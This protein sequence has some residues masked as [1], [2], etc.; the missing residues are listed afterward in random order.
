MKFLL[1]IP[2]ILTPLWA[3]AQTANCTQS[4]NGT[5]N[6]VTTDAYG[7]Q[8]TSTVTQTPNGFQIQGQRSN[9]QPFMP[10]AGTG[11]QHPNPTWNGSQPLIQ[12]GPVTLAPTR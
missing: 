7:N 10:G 6:C 1:A 9:T 8:R 11:I 2:I 3:S 5:Y 12:N 4:Y